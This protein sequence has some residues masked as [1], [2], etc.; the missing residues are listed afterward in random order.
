MGSRDTRIHSPR[1][2]LFYDSAF[3]SVL[4]FHLRR[5]PGRRDRRWRCREPF[6][7]QVS[8]NRSGIGN[9]CNYPHFSPTFR[10]YGDIEP[11]YA[12]QKGSPCEPVF[13]GA[14]FLPFLRGRIP[15]VLSRYDFRSKLGMRCEDP[16][17]SSGV[18]SRR[19][20]DRGELFEQFMTG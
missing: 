1:R 19:D 17:I 2:G 15:A 10:T 16:V 8:L 12:G 4:E 7:L 11:E 20:H 18:R 6:A 5:R 9:E 3:W 13:C 14:G